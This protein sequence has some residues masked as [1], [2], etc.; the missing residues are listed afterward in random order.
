MKKIDKT[1]LKET[2]FIAVVA[3]ILSVLMQAVFLII[4][5]WDY[6]VLCGNVL[7]YIACVG[8]FLLMGLTVQTAV[9]KEEKDAKSMMKL[10]QMLRNLLLF[11][12]A[13]LGHLLPV[14]NL[15]AV[16]IPFLFPRI[17]VSFRPLIKDKGGN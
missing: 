3:L 6:T 7:G 5:K 11:L 15:I 17:A 8:N 14:F 16:V 2:G 4:Q 10:S 9:L 13:L 1:V 12:V